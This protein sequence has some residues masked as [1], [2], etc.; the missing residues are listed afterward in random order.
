VRACAVILLSGL[1]AGGFAAAAPAAPAGWSAGRAIPGTADAGF[2]FDV[3][4]GPRGT[5]A[6]AF[7][8]RGVQ[9]ARRD[10]RGRWHAPERI[11]P[12]RASVTA[13]DVELTGKGEIV[14][15]WTQALTGGTLPP[16]GPNQ[17]RVA[18]R[19]NGAWRGRAVGRTRHFID[20]GLQLAVNSRGDA[21]VVWR[22]GSSDLLL[23][24][25]RPAAGAFRKGITLGEPGFDQRLAI[26]AQGR[27]FATWTRAIPPEYLTSQVRFASR[28]SRGGW[29]RPETV[30]AGRVG[31]AE[32][33]L[34]PGEAIVLAWR[35]DELGL[36]ATRTGLPVVAVR[37]EAGGWSAP[38]RL[39]EV[40]TQALH[41]GVSAGDEV[42][43]TWSATLPAYPATG[44]R[45]LYAAAR[46]RGQDFG[47]VV[48][49]SGM[50][51]GPLAVLAD[52]TAVTVAS[53]GGIDTSVRPPGGV[54]GAVGRLTNGGEFPSLSGWG[55]TAVAVWARGRLRAASFRAG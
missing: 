45:A 1:L 29:T 14:V 17:I 49:T 39:S 35:E 19:R 13:P 21:A 30:A 9:V 40:R 34:V 4:V 16:D 28:T 37:P 24:A 43:A 41:L 10:A 2:P 26:D 53:A 52:G 15:A 32:L 23:V 42:L 6:V 20:A 33:A 48:R 22:G 50:L 11:S 55:T 25:A 54:F 36:G 51:D 12:A 27:T 5:A 46:P 31:G 8:R 47:P 38:R 44:E 7:V 3:D 18:V